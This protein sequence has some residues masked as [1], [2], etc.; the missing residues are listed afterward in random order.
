MSR[1]TDQ[2]GQSTAWL[3]Q[4][5]NKEFGGW[6]SLPNDEHLSPLNTA[7]ALI[8][9]GASRRRLHR[10]RGRPRTVFDS[11]EQVSA[12]E[13]TMLERGRVTDYTDRPTVSHPDVVRTGL[14][15]EA[16]VLAAVPVD[17]VVVARAQTW[18]LAVQTKAGGWG[19][20]RDQPTR[21]LPT[22]QALLG[23]MAVGEHDPTVW[24]SV[25]RGIESLNRCRRHGGFFSSIDA[26]GLLTSPHTILRGPRHAAGEAPRPR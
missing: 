11:C 5:Q 22:C 25:H 16:L 21:V 6:G 23:L 15:L 24:D 7:E 14:A 19:C 13:A 20:A 1:L 10:Q 4:H 3:R 17:D 26:P 9:L 18:L 2:L 8:A 12:R